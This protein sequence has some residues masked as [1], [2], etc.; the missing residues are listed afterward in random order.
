MIQQKDIQSMV[1]TIIDEVHPVRIILF[2]SYATD[3]ATQDSDID[4]C[5]IEKDD[6]NA[7]RSRRKET[8]KLYKALSSYAIPKDLL[9]FSEEELNQEQNQHLIQPI[10]QQGKVLYD[11]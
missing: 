3:S 10:Q 6:F 2:G 7:E 5:I 11:A 1:N 8:A 4:L 9:L